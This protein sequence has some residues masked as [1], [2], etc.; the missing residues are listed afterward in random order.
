MN[1]ERHPFVYVA[2]VKTRC[3]MK[4]SRAMAFHLIIIGSME[5]LRRDHLIRVETIRKL[6]AC[7]T[8]T[9]ANIDEHGSNDFSERRYKVIDNNFRYD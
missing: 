3:Q 5:T 7:N 8:E 2:Y 1:V 4:N 6:L 9:N